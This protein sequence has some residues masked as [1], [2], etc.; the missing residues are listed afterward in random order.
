MT[1]IVTPIFTYI[2]YSL[3][4]IIKMVIIVPDIKLV[5]MIEMALFKEFIAGIIL[6]F[7]KGCNTK[8]G[9]P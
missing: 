1:I 2:G 4:K 3:T 5:T 6:P 8:E 7:T 9:E